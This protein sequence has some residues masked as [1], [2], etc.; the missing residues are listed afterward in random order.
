MASFKQ[1]IR[2]AYKGTTMYK[3]DKLLALESKWKRRQTIAQNKLLD[4]REAINT[5]ATQLAQAELNNN[6]AEAELSKNGAQ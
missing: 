2:E 6:L 3:L 4:V 5:L 1:T